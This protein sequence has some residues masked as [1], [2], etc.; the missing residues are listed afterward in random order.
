[1]TKLRV[2]G[3]EITVVDWTA[4]TADPELQRQIDMVM[5]K[6]LR[7][8]VNAEHELVHELIGSLRATLIGDPPPY[9]PCAGDVAPP[10]PQPANPFGNGLIRRGGGQARFIQPKR[11]R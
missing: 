10:R 9:N 8:L 11:R 5:D 7:P 6:L 1:M 2:N 4:K 3:D